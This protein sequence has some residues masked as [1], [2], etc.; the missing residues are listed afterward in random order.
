MKSYAPTVIEKNMGV[1][2][3]GS[4]EIPNL[5]E[6]ISKVRLL[7]LPLDDATQSGRLLGRE[8]SQTWRL[9]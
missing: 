5:A 3:R 4:G 6:S 2:Y 7:V 9:C 1:C 8:Y